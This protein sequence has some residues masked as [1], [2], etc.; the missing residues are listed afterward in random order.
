MN[1][2]HSPIFLFPLSHHTMLASALRRCTPAA[3]AAALVAAPRVAAAP[4]AAAVVAR[5]A[6]RCASSSTG[7]PVCAPFHH[8]FPVHDLAAG[9][10]AG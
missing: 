6:R 1:P 4:R 10:W 5:A 3:A 2:G 9:A 8:A 7:Y